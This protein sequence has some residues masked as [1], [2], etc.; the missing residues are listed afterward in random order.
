MK[1]YD[2]LLTFPSEA[3]A[4][5]ALPQLRGPIEGTDTIGWL[6]GPILDVQL[7]R[8][9]AVWDRADPEHPV[10]VSPAVIVPGWTIDDMQTEP[11]VE[12]AQALGVPFLIAD[13][14][15]ALRGEPFLVASSYSHEQIAG[16]LRASPEPAGAGYPLGG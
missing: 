10:L 7:I 6:P 1:V 2:R 4:A 8:A 13:R 5:A 14:E 3:A 12:A 16:I 11:Q 15:A 9:E